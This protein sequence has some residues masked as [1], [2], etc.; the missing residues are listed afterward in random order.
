MGIITSLLFCN[1]RVPINSG[2]ESHAIGTGQIF[3]VL[4]VV[5]DWPDLT[6]DALEERCLQ[7]PSVDRPKGL[8][9]AI[10]DNPASEAAPQTGEAYPAV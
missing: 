4:R 6:W 1:A 8:S 7:T 5:R 2:T 3:R 9:T 10:D